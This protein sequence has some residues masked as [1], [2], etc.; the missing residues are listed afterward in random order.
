MTDTLRAAPLSHRV[1][2]SDLVLAWTSLAL[3]AVAVVMTVR[4]TEYAWDVEADFVLGPDQDQAFYG[5]TYFF[6]AVVL[7]PAVLAHLV[8][9][10]V[11]TYRAVRGR[12]TQG[13][14][15]VTAWVAYVLGVLCVGAVCAMGVWFAM[16]LD[17]APGSWRERAI[18]YSAAPLLVAAVAGVVPLLWARGGEEAR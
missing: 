12:P 1:L 14:G 6:Y 10:V 4:A 15:W 11:T 7:A 3:F 8:S 2:R 9:V 17:A 16:G 18:L 13:A 5:L